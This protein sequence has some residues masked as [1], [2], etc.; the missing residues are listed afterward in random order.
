MPHS[1][2][3]QNWKGY[4][5]PFVLPPENYKAYKMFPVQFLFFN[6]STFSKKLGEKYLNQ[7]SNPFQEAKNE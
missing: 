6:L 5:K 7:N 3:A 4:K 2:P 1:T